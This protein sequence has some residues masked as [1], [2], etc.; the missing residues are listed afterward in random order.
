MN[1]PSTPVAAWVL[2][3]GAALAS[4]LPAAAVTAATTPRV[5]GFDVE[6]VM[7]LNPGT[8]LSFTVWGTPGAQA[9]LQ[10]DGAQRALALIET[11]PGIYRG[12]YTRR[13]IP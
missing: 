1:I 9:A 5:T 8:D 11:S 2:A 6:Q 10:I 3:I 7:Q 4:P 12:T 13:P